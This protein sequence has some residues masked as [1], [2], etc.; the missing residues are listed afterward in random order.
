VTATIKVT[1]TKAGTLENIVNVTGNRI[2]PNLNNNEDSATTSVT[3]QGSLK[4]QNYHDRNGNGQKDGND[5]GLNGW[6]LVLYDAQNKVVAS[7]KTQQL[8]GEN[9]WARFDKLSP[10]TYKVCE[11]L[12]SQGG[13]ANS[14]PGG[15]GL[16]KS[17]T[18]TS[19]TLEKVL[20]LGN[21]QYGS[22]RVVKESN[23]IYTFAFTH[24]LQAFTL[25]SNSLQNSRKFSDLSPGS[26]L[27][28]EDPA[29][30]P[31]ENWFLAQ[32]VCQDA[33]SQPAPVIVDLPKLKAT[34]PLSSGQKLTCTFYNDQEAEE[35]SHGVYLPLILHE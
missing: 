32:V 27:I 22:L 5:S 23:I 1:P 30:L 19:D 14:D 25:T 13:W 21:Y 33:N 18:L 29:S 12:V 16:C 26:Y 15:G 6:T 10:G 11:L 9:G 20:L 31:N 24:N 28:A 34:I 17:T 2:D 4:I 8:N 35:E 3:A 7:K